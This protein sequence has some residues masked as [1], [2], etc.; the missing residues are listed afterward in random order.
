QA[1]TWST[2]GC[3]AARSIPATCAARSTK[4]LMATTAASDP[5][6][7]GRKPGPRAVPRTLPSAAISATSVLLLPASIASTPGRAG[8]R[9]IG[10]RPSQVVAVVRD[11]AVG[12]SV[13]E[14]DL[15]DQRMGEQGVEDAFAPTADGGVEREPLVRGDV[16]DQAGVKGF[17]RS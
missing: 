14:V 16:R 10:S 12:K 5:S 6:C 1:E 4:G 3:S 11:E 8:G 9:L 7:W 2:R 13:R 17:E 15:S